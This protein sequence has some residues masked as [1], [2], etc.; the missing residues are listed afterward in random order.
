MKTCALKIKFCI[1]IPLVLAAVSLVALK[2]NS[3]GK[4]NG[5]MEKLVE[6]AVEAIKNQNNALLKRLLK[7]NKRLANET[8]S[9]DS[10]LLYLAIVEDNAGAVRLLANAGAVINPPEVGGWTYLHYAVFKKKYEIVKTLLE[11][12]ANPEIETTQSYERRRDHIIFYENST[13]LDF[14][15]LNN[16]VEIARLFL[17]KIRKKKYLRMVHR[18]F[19]F[20]SIYGHRKMQKY[21]IRE[22]SQPDVVNEDGW[23]LLHVAVNNF[24]KIPV[25]EMLIEGGASLTQKTG[26]VYKDYTGRTFPAGS[27]PA[28]IAEL[29]GQEKVLRFLLEKGGNISREDPSKSGYQPAYLNRAEEMAV[30]PDGSIWLLKSDSTVFFTEKV[31]ELWTKSQITSEPGEIDILSSS[32]STLEFLGPKIAFAAGS[33]P[34]YI[35]RTE[36]RG[37]SWREIKFGEGRFFVY[38]IYG[39][40]NGEAWL[41]G[42]SGDI[43]YSNDYAAT[44]TK[45]NSPFDHSS[46]MYA[47]YMADSNEGIAGS[48]DNLLFLT[49]D[50]WQSSVKIPTPLD[51]QVVNPARRPEGFHLILEVA[52]WKDFLVVNQQ[53]EIFYSGQNSIQWRPFKEDLKDFSLDEESGKLFAV[54]RS[55]HVIAYSGIDSPVRLS[56]QTL[57]AEPYEC[58]AMKDCLYVVDMESCIYKVKSLEFVREKILAAY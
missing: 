36:D 30:A 48:C 14:A 13:P 11:C 43:Y 50:N 46:R 10:E 35:L 41:G 45:R 38:D 57:K 51:Q 37:K 19:L 20:A 56:N 55:L 39:K 8:D 44:W 21:L 28:D 40:S 17:R 34:G 22:C 49:A 24:A 26:T 42:S 47:I 3:A 52:V 4:V 12:G 6:R 9:D 2:G 18:L 7:K 32:P 5:N 53:G 29:S 23:T 54:T 58:K 1:V 31:G 27:T 16:D 33:L 25:I 15:V